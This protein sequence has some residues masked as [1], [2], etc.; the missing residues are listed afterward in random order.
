MKISKP[1]SLL[2]AVVAGL[3]SFGGLTPPQARAEVSYGFF[4][5]TLDPYGEWVQVPDY[6]YV[7]HPTGV[8]ENWAPYTDGY[9]AYTDGGWTWVSYE[10]YGGVVYHY[11]RWTRIPGEGW[12]WVPGDTWAPAWVSWRVSDDYVG[13]APLPPEAHW[14]GGIGFG[15]WVDA[16]FDI[17]PGFYSFVGV[18]DFG[19]PALGAVILSR[20]QNVT[21]INNTTN[22]TNITVNNSNV[23]TGGPSYEKIAA[24]SARPIPTLKLVRQGDASLVRAQGGKALS[25]QQGNQ[26]VMIAPKIAESAKGARPTPPKVAKTLAGVKADHGWD[27]VKDPQEREKLQ[28]KIKGQSSG[29]EAVK[30]VNPADLKMVDEKIKSQGSTKAAAAEQTGSPAIAEATPKAGKGKGA[31]KA[32]STTDLENA[33]ATEEPGAAA[34]SASPKKGK[35]KK[36]HATPAA[37]SNYSGAANET[38]IPKKSKKAKTPSEYESGS[39]MEAETPSKHAKKSSDSNLQPFLGGG[40]TSSSPVEPKVK[41]SSEYPKESENPKSYEG[42]PPVTA[43]P[44]AIEARSPKSAK[45]EKGEKDDKKKKEDQGYPPGQ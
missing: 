4:Y 33:P 39:A 17:G 2:V 9:W 45:G 34:A 1:L 37:E 20:D 5:D 19:A 44:G 13:W 30:P 35:G 36:A 31:K 24:R 3:I 18:R 38:P 8:D 15:T 32:L 28:A 11:G 26:L 43:Y 25:H 14:R 16:R 42:R 22:I 40:D 41:K 12:V 27:V 10:D 6:G 21:I 29:T 23:Y 7:W